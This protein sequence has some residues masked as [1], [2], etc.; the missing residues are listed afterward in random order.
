MGFTF[1][2]R[3]RL[4][5]GIHLNVSNTGASVSAGIK[6]LRVTRGRGRTTL[7]AGL[8]GTGVSYQKSVSDRAG[9]PAGRQRPV[10]GKLTGWLLRLLAIAMALSGLGVTLSLLVS[11]V[12][13]ALT[14][15]FVCAG[16]FSLL[17]WGLWSLGGRLI[18]R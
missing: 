18:R 10:F 11:D 3:I 7:S 9:M 4:L 15:L 2:K 17:A 13:G 14:P 16:A 1:R 12:K 5:K 6:G 8:P